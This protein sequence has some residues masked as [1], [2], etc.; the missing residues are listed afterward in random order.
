MKI[1]KYIK[2]NFKKYVHIIGIILWNL[3]LTKQKVFTPGY[4]I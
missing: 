4:C 3:N 1:E 2:Y